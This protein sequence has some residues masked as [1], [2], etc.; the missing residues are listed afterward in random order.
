[1]ECTQRDE[2]YKWKH[3]KNTYIRICKRKIKMRIRL[4][5]TCRCKNI[6]LRK[7]I[8]FWFKS[9]TYVIITIFDLYK[10]T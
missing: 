3:A 10:K 2:A 4:R 7:I 8:V 6:K 1:M 5:V 9:K